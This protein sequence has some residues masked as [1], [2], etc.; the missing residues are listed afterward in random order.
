MGGGEM[1]RK[2]KSRKGRRNIDLKKRRGVYN[3]IIE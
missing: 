1:K 3:I 2:K